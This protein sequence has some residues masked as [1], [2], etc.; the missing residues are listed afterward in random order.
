MPHP[1]INMM[2]TCGTAARGRGCARRHAAHG[3]DEGQL[4]MRRGVGEKCR[5]TPPQSAGERRPYNRLMQSRTRRRLVV[6]GS[7]RRTAGRFPPAQEND[8]NEP[9]LSAAQT[10]IQGADPC[11][12]TKA[13]IKRTTESVT[14]ELTGVCSARRANCSR[15]MPVRNWRTNPLE[16]VTH[17]EIFC[18]GPG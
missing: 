15:D 3:E 17:V 10:Y 13:K 14:A 2:A 8:Q 4:D 11:A 12:A 6:F 16:A 7:T 5:Q 9:R 1:R 18:R